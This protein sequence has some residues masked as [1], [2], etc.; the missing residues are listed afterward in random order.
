MLSKLS[1]LIKEMKVDSLWFGSVL[2]L[3][4]T[5][6]HISMKAFTPAHGRLCLFPELDLR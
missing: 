6:V 1:A 3:A 5:R 2:R 4:W